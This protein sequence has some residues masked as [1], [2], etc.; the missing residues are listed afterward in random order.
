MPSHKH[1]NPTDRGYN[2]ERSE[3]QLQTLTPE[4]R[5][6]VGFLSVS[7][8]NSISRGLHFS[9]AFQCFCNIRSTQPTEDDRFSCEFI[10]R[11]KLAE[12]YRTF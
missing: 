10:G 1:P 9:V 8:E 4:N 6:N 2:Q 3:T 7:V 12:K 11:A 5:K